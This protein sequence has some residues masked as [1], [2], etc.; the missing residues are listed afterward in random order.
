MN[1]STKL[2][3]PLSTLAVA[4]AVA[5]GSGATWSSTTESTITATAGTLVQTNSQNGA[6]LNVTNLKPGAVE[7]GSLTVANTGD[8]DGVLT[9]VGTSTD[10]FVTGDVTLAITVNGAPYWSGNFADVDDVD[11]DG[12]DADIATGLQT[13][14]GIPLGASDP[15]EDVVVGFTVTM[16]SDA[17][18]ANQ[19][20]SATAELEFVMTQTTDDESG[21][22]WT[23]VDP[24]VGTTG[25][26]GSD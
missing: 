3:V 2:L 23:P 22:T 14:L 13:K 6:T 7:T 4:A 10:T 8:L 15:D 9:L 16:A 19:G 17:A 5:V 18:H 1:T 11:D 20:E 24:A 12:V 26:P 21:A 25:S